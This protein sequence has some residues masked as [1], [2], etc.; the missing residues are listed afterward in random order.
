MEI[1]N[2]TFPKKSKESVAKEN[3]NITNLIFKLYVL[4]TIQS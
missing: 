1:N 2:S 4:F 3:K